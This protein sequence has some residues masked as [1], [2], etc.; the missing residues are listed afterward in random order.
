MYCQTSSSVQF[1]SGKT[2]ID[3]PRCFSALKRLQSSGRWFFGSQ[4]WA[5]ERK[6]KIRSFARDFSS[7]TTSRITWML[8][9]SSRCRW[10][11]VTVCPDNPDIVYGM[12]DKMANDLHDHRAA[13]AIAEAAGALLLEVRATG[14][15]D[16]GAEGDRRA[17][18][19]I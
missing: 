7:A 10:V 17:N 6:E 9:A 15:A 1:E 2:R 3:S 13:A 18:E 5:A 16:V 14:A 19:L 8:S 11:R 4:R 12:S